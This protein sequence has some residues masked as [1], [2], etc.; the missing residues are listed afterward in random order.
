MK[1][2][3]GF[4][5]LLVLLIS[6]TGKEKGNFHFFGRVTDRLTHQPV[7]GVYVCLNEQYHR[8]K[9]ALETFGRVYTNT[10]GEYDF[11]MGYY[12]KG[13]EKTEIE[14]SHA[15]VVDR[16]FRVN[17]IYEGENHY[18]RE[19]ETR[20][21]L[22][23]RIINQWPVDQ[24]DS[25]FDIYIARPF[26]RQYVSEGNPAYTG[27]SVSRTDT[28]SFFGFSTHKLHYS[29][30][31]NNIIHQDSVTVNVADPYATA[32]ENVTISY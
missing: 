1:G 31:K 27:T 25:I 23:V 11:T 5:F 13:E 28:T 29:F 16:F 32:V 2:R 8:G 14:T 12:Y 21:K 20:S 9:E 7:P 3:I 10:N 17:G 19:V 6:C 30:R 18:D 24:H 4:V 15:N 22:A 26:G